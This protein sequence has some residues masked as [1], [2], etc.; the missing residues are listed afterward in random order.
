MAELAAAGPHVDR[1]VV[2]TVVFKVFD[3]VHRLELP[4]LL[5]GAPARERGA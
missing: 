1:V 3:A 5:L 4:L 2:P